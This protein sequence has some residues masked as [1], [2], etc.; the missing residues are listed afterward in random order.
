MG[1]KSSSKKKETLQNPS[2]FSVSRSG[3]IF[4]CSWS[5]GSNY[6]AQ[7]AMCAVDVGS[8]GV[9]VAKDATSVAVALPMNYPLT[10]V[11]FY[12]R[13]KLD[14]K[15]TAWN[16]ATFW[17]GPPYAPV[18]SATTRDEFNVSTFSW[19]CSASDSDPYPFGSVTW[20]SILVKNCDEPNGA[21][22]G[23]DSS[24][25]GWRTGV[26]TS[27]T[28]TI[29]IQEQT[30]DTSEDVTSTRWFRA[31]SNGCAGSSGWVYAKI[32][33][34]SPSKISIISANVQ[35]TTS[36]TY[37]CSCSWN[38]L[39]SVSRPIGNVTVQYAIVTPEENMSFPSGGNWSDATISADSEGVDSSTF[40]IDG[41]MASD[42]VIFV[43]ANSNFGNRRTEGDPYVA[44][45]G[46]LKKPSAL[47]VEAN[48][49][50]HK[51]KVNATNNSGVPDAHLAVVYRVKDDPN[52]SFVVGIIPHG[53]SSATFQCPNW[54]DETPGFGVYAF[55][56]SYEE[57]E[58]ADGVNLYSIDAKMLSE[59]EWVGGA[60]PI[61]PANV[62][63]QPTSIMG[64]IRVTW[65]WSWAEA[66]SAVI[67]WADHED[68]WESTDEP[69]EYTISNLHASRWNISG[70]ETGKKWYVAV[71]LV[72]EETSG[73]WSEPIA[74]DLTSAPAVPVLTASNN[75]I[76]A[77]GNVTLY[78][79]FVSTDGTKQSYAEIC[80]AT[81][82]GG[83]VAHGDIIAHTETEQQIT[84][85]AEEKG[86][87]AGDV[88]HLC[89]RVA[90]ASGRR[91]DEWSAPI[92]IIVADAINAEI[93]S[94]SLVEET[95]TVEVDG[96]QESITRLKLKEL[97]LTVNVTGA[98]EGGTTSVTVVR[99]KPFH[100]RRPDES[101]YDGYE[102]ETI[103]STEFAGE[104]TATFGIGDLI[105]T[106]DDTA[107]YKL[108]ATVK[109]SYGQ[110]DTATIDE[111]VVDWSHQADA[112]LEADVEIDEDE[113]YATIT[114]T[115]PAN[116][117]GTDRCDIY[118]L[119]ADKPELVVKG[120][121]FGVAYVDPYPAIN[122]GYRFV[123]VTANGDYRQPNSMPAWVDY[124]NNW[125][126]EYSIIDFNGQQVLLHYNI[127]ISNNWEK[128]FKATK[129]LGGSVKGDW[130]AGVIRTSKISTVA[131]TE[132]NADVIEQLR[133]LAIYTGICHV[134]TL[135]GSSYSAD[136]QV[137]EDRDHGDYGVK[138]SFSLSGTRVD[139]ESPEG[140]TFEQWIE[141]N[142]ELE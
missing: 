13:G 105:G 55:V 138:A 103:A 65:D 54:G 114:V 141:G 132:Y 74:L 104:G 107:S 22:L 37:T 48:E 112:P 63:V 110:I 10:Y 1:K 30:S 86:W 102:G 95:D 42:Q 116:A 99:A 108:I 115:A 129:Y 134:R 127:D 8:W 75:V 5:R 38:A 79:S 20:Q 118:R 43:R 82:N 88:K 36:A 19:T 139:P 128:G 77:E 94:T 60:V 23:W 28:G 72:K 125:D 9:G 113:L 3:N 97:P 66:D 53:D 83:D 51:V 130:D 41:V 32:V 111:F 40:T 124:D 25:Y 64:T 50:T 120:A 122:G 106:F 100:M 131:F 89:V 16:G 71:K 70:L 69:S 121:E 35:K 34:A 21:N 49:S 2:G 80:E 68:A 59:E 6:S 29:D 81:I 57:K 15:W 119:S 90:S 26:S 52:A 58:R 93:T 92:T 67:S 87:N 135:D 11:T 61:A 44:A 73:P 140:M 109:D 46:Q 117:V 45:Y 84:I 101:D 123:T 39:Q 78:W 12:V 56:G 14:K 62:T 142:D 126:F 31:R 18:L 47:S 17:M 85:N 76:S 136:V 33:Y 91:S 98:K 133:N 96:E 27:P 4:S 24:A 137:Q 7:E